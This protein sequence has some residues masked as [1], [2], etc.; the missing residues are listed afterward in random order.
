MKNALFIQHHA[1]YQGYQAQ[2]TLDALLVMAAF[3]QNPSVLFQGDGVWQLVANQQPKHI[4]RA[5]IVAQLQALSL[6][7]VERVY[8]DTF[9]LQQRGLTLADITIDAQA[10]TAQELAHFIHQ[11][12]MIIRL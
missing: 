4:G 11:H 12:D 10:I 9:S 8:V 2:E 6:Y 5:S 3:G 1:P 7:D